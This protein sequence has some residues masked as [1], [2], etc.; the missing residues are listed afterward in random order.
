MNIC[1]LHHDH[2][3]HHRL[4]VASSTSCSQAG[5]NHPAHSLWGSLF[6][7]LLLSTTRDA[8]RGGATLLMQQLIL[9]ESGC[10]NTL[11]SSLVPVRVTKELSSRDS[12]LQGQ[13]T[14]GWMK[15][16]C[17]SRYVGY[18]LREFLSAVLVLLRLEPM[19]SRQLQDLSALDQLQYEVLQVS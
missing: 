1:F 15:Q 16:P 3:S 5:T 2:G 12:T 14:S 10:C 13:H 6:F 9:L 4:A 8:R 19:R 7:G 11:P 17:H 18:Q